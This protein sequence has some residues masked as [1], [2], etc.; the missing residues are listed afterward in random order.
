MTA[1]NTGFPHLLEVLKILEGGVNCD[2]TKAIAYG[3]QLA[4]KLDEEGHP[5]AAASIR[6]VLDHVKSLE[7]N[8]VRMDPRVH[9]LPVDS[10]SRLS[11]GDEEHVE[12]HDA[13]VVL[14]A[15]ARAKVEEFLA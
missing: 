9:R 3:R 2:P 8:A 14:P 5:R 11:L 12:L 4:D 1:R 6:R 13:E 15:A 7:L 10:E